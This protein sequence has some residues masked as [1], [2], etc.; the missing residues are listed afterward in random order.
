MSKIN[1]IVQ[2]TLTSNSRGVTR[3]SFGVP[4]VLGYHTKWGELYRVYSSSTIFKDLTDEGFDSKSPIMNEV[5]SIIAN[6]PKPTKIV[7]GRL[8]TAPAI[9]KT[10][11]V[12]IS[13]FLEGETVS[14]SVLQP[15][16]TST[17]I[18]YEIQAGDTDDDVATALASDISAITGVVA[19]A[20]TDT[21]TVSFTTAGDNVYFVGLPKAFLFE[22]TTAD[23]SLATEIAAVQAAYPEH[24]GLLLAEGQSTARY[25]IVAGIVATQERILGATTYNSSDLDAASTTS[26]MYALEAL[27]NNRTFVIYSA[28]QDSS[29]AASWI[30]RVFP[31]NAGSATWAYKNLGGETAED[32]SENDIAAIEGN[33]GNYYIDIGGVD[34]TLNGKMAGGSWIDS[35]RGTDWLTARLRETIANTLVNA[36]K[37]PYTNAGI[38]LF[39]KDIKAVF[40]QATSPG[41]D[42]IDPEQNIIVTQPDVEDVDVADKRLR[43]LPDLYAEGTLQGAI[44]SV[45]VGVY[46]KV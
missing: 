22:D 3:K 44:H 13:G 25:T 6:N 20:V 41:R 33:N 35:V 8:T 42:F 10:I 45:R 12:D 1:D 36:K 27:T 26:T 17:T 9:T 2:I 43:V 31:L 7:V 15:D 40:K 21:I 29:K 11:Q 23:S 34:A 46:L 5:N 39:S 30:G 4:L 14:F 28:K 32:L 37:V 18:S 16:A 38:E 19:A 24:Y